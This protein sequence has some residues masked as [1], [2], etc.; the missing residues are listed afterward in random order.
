MSD[1]SGH[2]PGGGHPDAKTLVWHHVLWATRQRT[3]VLPL[4]WRQLCL[5]QEVTRQKTDCRLTPCFRSEQD[6]PS[7][8]HGNGRQ[9]PNAGLPWE[10]DV[11]FQ[12]PSLLALCPRHHLYWVMLSMTQFHSAPHHREKKTVLLWFYVKKHFGF[13]IRRS[14][15]GKSGTI[16]SENGLSNPCSSAHAC[17]SLFTEMLTVIWFYNYP[18][19]YFNCFPNG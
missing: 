19:N 13:S 4:T 7:S 1:L 14:W 12:C 17:R 2:V 11:V 18:E 6:I 16:H 8:E 3:R 9:G 10:W 15:T 5:A